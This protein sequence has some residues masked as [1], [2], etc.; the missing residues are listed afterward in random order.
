M[1]AYTR[2]RLLV[3]RSR[4]P[5]LDRPA[6]RVGPAKPENRK[7]YQA[8]HRTKSR[9]KSRP[10][11]AQIDENSMKNRARVALGQFGAIK[12][13]SG[14]PREASGTAPER[15]KW[16]RGRSWEA[17][18]GFRTVPGAS[19]KR[20]GGSWDALGTTSGAVR[21]LPWHRALSK[22]L[23]DRIFV[24]FVS[25]RESSDVLR[26]PRFVVFCCSWTKKATNGREGRRSSKKQGF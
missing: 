2:W 5:N 21:S 9:R 8:E 18:G 24:V 22:R 16:P 3:D 13:D 4:S 19:G 17:A 6:Y 20:P 1:Y 11:R 10:K 15:K 26:V 25:S 14:A 23:A 7:D 12:V